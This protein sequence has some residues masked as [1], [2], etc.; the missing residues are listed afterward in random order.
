MYQRTIR[1]TKSI[2]AFQKFSGLKFLIFSVTFTFFAFISTSAQEL[3]PTEIAPPPLKILAKTDKEQLEAENDL[4][5]RTKLALEFIEARMKQAEKFDSEDNF[6]QMYDELGKFQA[7]IDYTLD[8][9]NRSNTGGK[10]L[11]NFKRFEIG[12]RAY[13]PRLETMRR[14]LPI[15][16]EKYVRNLIQSIRDTRSKAVDNFFADSVVPNVKS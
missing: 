6:S 4:K 12:L 13:P 11:N 9:L 14:S 2:T 15:K 16:Y 5:D 7:L 8:F 1:G 3:S 10:A